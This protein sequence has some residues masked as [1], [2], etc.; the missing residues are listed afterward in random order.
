M[1]DGLLWYSAGEPAI[2]V[3]K[4]AEAFHRKYNAWPNLCYANSDNIGDRG[5]SI[6]VGLNVIRVIPKGFVL[7]NHYQIG[8][9]DAYDKEE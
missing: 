8:T 1:Q 4:A 5:I 9:A 2:A 6:K 3:E 7:K